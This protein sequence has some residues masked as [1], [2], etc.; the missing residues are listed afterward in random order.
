MRLFFDLVHVLELLLVGCLL[1][2]CQA[3]DLRGKQ[4][5]LIPQFFHLTLV[6]YLQVTFLKFNQVTVLS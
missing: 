3:V 4:A 2:E 1:L 6:F 5:D